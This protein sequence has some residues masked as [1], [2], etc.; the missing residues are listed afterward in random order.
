MATTEELCK[1]IENRDTEKAKICIEEGTEVKGTDRIGFSA[2]SHAAYNGMIEIADLLIQHGADVNE[3]NR[4]GCPP[5]AYAI[6]YGGYEIAEFL[7]EKGADINAHCGQ[8]GSVPLPQWIIN[9]CINDHKYALTTASR[10]EFLVKHGANIKLISISKLMDVYGQDANEII[11]LM[12]PKPSQR[13]DTPPPLPKVGTP[14]PF[15]KMK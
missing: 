4:L 6:S 12:N 1:A 7:L 5:L 10:V 14:P 9:T 13:M 15:P 2:L 8:G 3:P 11:E